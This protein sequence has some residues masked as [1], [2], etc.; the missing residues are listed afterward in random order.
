[1]SMGSLGVGCA[2]DFFFSGLVRRPFL[3]AS[4]IMPGAGSL[5]P[6]PGPGSE[7]RRE[8]PSTSL[9]AGEGLLLWTAM[10]KP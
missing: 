4:G 7:G 5:C 8:G 1:M 10:E 6:V 3:V 9:R 2:P